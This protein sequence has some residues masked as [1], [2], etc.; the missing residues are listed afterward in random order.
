M[1]QT[2]LKTKAI[3][4]RRTNYGEADRILTILTPDN[5]QL[6]VM[7]K[8][9]WRERS[10]LAGGIEL[11]AVCELSL[12]R[13]AQNK[14]GMWTLT[15]SKIITFYDQIMTD[16]DRL[17]MGYEIL[18]QVGRLSDVIETPELYSILAQSLA[19]LNDLQLDLRLIKAWFYL[20]IAKIKGAELN[21]LTDRNGM[22]LVED[23][24]YNYDL[25]ERTLVYVENGPYTTKV[26]KLLR[27]L[28][29]QP[30]AVTKRLTGIT[31][32]EIGQALYL[33]RVAAESG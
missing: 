21:L 33:A 25:G 23:A 9:V 7:A 28:N 2:N 18:K 19:G 17:Q 27:V 32:N 3:I 12:V 1:T 8:A 20:Q 10:K 5:G 31:D 11:F 6:S 30:L 14:S 29:G 16:F 22:K 15:S 4:L 26:I 13:G 24:T